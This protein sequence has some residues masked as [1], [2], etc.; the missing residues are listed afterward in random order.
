MTK[1]KLRI[2]P[3]L[4]KLF[5]KGEIGIYVENAQEARELLEALDN[6]GY[7]WNS[8]HS[9]LTHNSSRIFIDASTEPFSKPYLR[10]NTITSGEHV[11]GIVKRSNLGGFLT[12]NTHYHISEFLLPVY[13]NDIRGLDQ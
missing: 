5:N 4:H 12:L 2:D 8:G 3:K 7:K 10:F 9:L 1:S 13:E 11:G 6:Y